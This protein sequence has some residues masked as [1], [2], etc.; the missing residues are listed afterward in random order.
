MSESQV[1]G[2]S[3]NQM[4]S[5]SRL[6]NHRDSNE[7]SRAQL[8]SSD[9]HREPRR[10]SMSLEPSR[11]EHDTRSRN[12]RQGSLQVQGGTSQL[13]EEHRHSNV[14]RENNQQ[15]TD[16]SHTDIHNRRILN[17]HVTVQNH[18]PR[19]VHAT[20]D[21]H[22]TRDTSDNIRRYSEHSQSAHYHQRPATEPRTSGD[23]PPVDVITHRRRDFQGVSSAR[24]RG[25]SAC[26]L[27]IS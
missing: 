17:G 15:T 27:D 1:P 10:P 20:R 13:T 2:D 9:A 24:T 18:L 23:L 19:E 26:M 11:R 22:N 7:T 3:T 12:A 21:I 25:S 5:I 16:H 6:R 8:A 4:L 14:R